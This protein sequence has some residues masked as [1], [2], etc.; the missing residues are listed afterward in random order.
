M[1]LKIN[2]HEIQLEIID[3]ISEIRINIL[4]ESDE[5]IESNIY[6][7]IHKLLMNLNKEQYEIIN[8]R[9]IRLF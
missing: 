6:K 1:K 9:L 5:F 4:N 8:I 2:N 3:N 7:I